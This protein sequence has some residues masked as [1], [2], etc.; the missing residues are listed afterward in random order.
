MLKNEFI[1][2]NTPY[3]TTACDLYHD[4]DVDKTPDWLRQLVDTIKSEWTGIGCNLAHWKK[5]TPP[6]SLNTIV[7]FPLSSIHAEMCNG[8]GLVE[9]PAGKKQQRR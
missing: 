1:A 5:K 9:T 8:K 2:V 4:N 3:F 6:T 7:F